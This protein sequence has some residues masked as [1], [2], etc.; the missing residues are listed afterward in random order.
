MLRTIH[1]VSSAIH[2][3]TRHVVRDRGADEDKYRGICYIPN[4]ALRRKLVD[5]Q[6][7]AV[8]GRHGDARDQKCFVR[9]SK[10]PNGEMVVKRLVVGAL[11][12]SG[13]VISFMQV[14]SGIAI[15]IGEADGRDLLDQR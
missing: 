2:Q 15:A 9:H 8:E 4:L 5:R 1:A 14:H 7:V 3:R 6:L 12:I 11:W 10:K 13:E